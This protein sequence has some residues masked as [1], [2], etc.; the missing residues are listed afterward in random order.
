MT[1]T[2]SSP[3]PQTLST[4]FQPSPLKP[5]F[6]G[7][8]AH[9]YNPRTADQSRALVIANPKVGKSTFLRSIPG[10]I[11][12][13]FE[14]G[15]NATTCPRAYY[16]D[17]S[18]HLT[19]GE[20]PLTRFDRVKTLLLQDA[21]TPTP[22]F[23]TVVI[24]TVDAWVD[25]LAAHILP[26]HKDGRAAWGELQTVL[27]GHLDDLAQAGY[28]VYLGAHLNT[29][30][31]TNDNGVNQTYTELSAP[32]SIRK[33]LVRWVDQLMILSATAEVVYPVKKIKLPDGKV[34]EV[35]DKE[36]GQKTIRV[37]LDAKP[38]GTG[39]ASGSRVTVDHLC[40]PERDG[41]AA[42]A[43]AYAAEVERVR[44]SLEA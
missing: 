38:A 12:L 25:R 39:V 13:D 10:A 37:W 33:R 31:L 44:A 36:N 16:A 2:T 20:A 41:Y 40:V 43:Q 15:A 19:G 6:D 9:G 1:T 18:G 29:K 11:V 30:I 22:Q 3:A 7:L 21:K 32:E 35:Q 28:G 24:D 8:V 27:M 14:G 23:K 4:P 34:R 17:L 5:A 42:Y 26:N